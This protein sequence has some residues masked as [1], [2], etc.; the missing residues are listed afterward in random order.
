[1]IWKTFIL[2]LLP[3]VPCF[4]WYIATLEIYVE[5]VLSYWETDFTKI[6]YDYIVVGGGSAGCVLARRLSEDSKT[7]VALVEAGGT[8]SVLTS[9]PALSSFL[10][11]SPLDWAHSTVPQADACLAMD[12][13]R[14]LWPRG[15]MLGGSSNLNYML[16]V[17]GDKQDYDNWANLTKDN[18][19]SFQN[20]LQYFKKS[21]GQYGTYS[22]DLNSHNK[23]GLYPVTDAVY[24]TDFVNMYRNVSIENGYHV[25]DINAA[26]GTIGGK[27]S[28]KPQVNLN[29]NGRR[30]DT[31]RTY[32]A[33]VLNRENLYI[34]KYATVSSLL[35][36]ETAHANRDS[37]LKAVGIEFS[38]FGHKQRIYSNHEV[39]LAAGTI[40]SPMI[41]MHSG[42][43]SK[44]SLEEVG[45]KVIKDLSHVGSNLKD[46]VC[47]MIGPF[48]PV[49]ESGNIDMTFKSFDIVRDLTMSNV[50]NYLV[51][52]VGPLAATGAVDAMSFFNTNQ[53]PNKNDNH[54]TNT[55]SSNEALNTSQPNMQVHFFGLT[56]GTDYGSSLYQTLGMSKELW[57]KFASPSYGLPGMMTLPVLL[58]PKSQV[59]SIQ[60]SS[61]DPSVPPLIDPKY[62]FNAEDAKTLVTGI[63]HLLHMM[64]KASV[65]HGSKTIKMKLLPHLFP[66]CTLDIINEKF[67][68]IDDE[69]IAE[70]HFKKDEYWECY[71]RHLTLTMY[72]PVG[73]CKMGLNEKDS[74]VDSELRVH[75]ITGLR[76]ADASIMPDIVSGNTNAPTVMIAEVAADLV[77]QDRLKK[78]KQFVN[79]NENNYE[80]NDAISED[81]SSKIE[82]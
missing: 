32:L 73:T 6:Q 18:R 49:D 58:H 22:N 20:V 43:G 71:I 14:C 38:R 50:Y 80:L 51:H 3:F 17:R 1:M 35:F 4:V 15:K 72:H 27:F 65:V 59:G 19:W 33:D 70:K 75:G 68:D 11:L 63:K 29:T 57:D 13:K 52:G 28:I 47:T 24:S 30:A 37:N 82:L 26:D 9:I 66:R 8:P 48:L 77:I 69:T 34:I 60:L 74:V 81:T 12:E 79:T 25:R 5:H 23:T 40:G 36:D 2:F 62:Y 46:H 39:I 21:E 55:D 61:A 7:K 54:G 10:Q 67:E 53:L 56:F 31:Y 64:E 76:V 45:I 44:T 16:Y 42:I 41:L 78:T